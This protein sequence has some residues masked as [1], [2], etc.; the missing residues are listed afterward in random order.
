MDDLSTTTQSLVHA[1]QWSEWTVQGVG[2][3]E[4]CFQ[5]LARGLVLVAHLAADYLEE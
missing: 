3:A 2:L 4:N 1:I 5:R